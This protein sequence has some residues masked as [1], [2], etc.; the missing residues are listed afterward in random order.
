MSCVRSGVCL[1]LLAWFSL[2]CGVKPPSTEAPRAQ[3]VPTPRPLRAEASDAKLELA[4]QNDGILVKAPWPD[5]EI[6]RGHSALELYGREVRVQVKSDGA[7]LRDHPV[8]DGRTLHYVAVSTNGDYAAATI[9]TPKVKL[10]RVQRPRLVMDKLHYTLSVLDGDTTVKTYAAGLGSDPRKRKICQDNMTTPEG[11]YTIYNLQPEATFF[12]AY[13][14]DYPNMIDRLRY[15]I[16]Q[17]TGLVPSDRGI[18]GEIQIHGR[19]SLGNWTFG[20]ISLDDDD[21]AELFEHPDLGVG[22]ELFICGTEIKLEDRPWL[23]APPPEKVRTVQLAL[24]RSGYYQ[25]TAD[26]LL[27]SQTQEALGRYQVA[28][29]LPLTCQLDSA[30]RAHFQLSRF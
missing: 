25:G 17:E 11:L 21:I 29:K 26:G 15:Q 19:G 10:G 2:G 12:K 13:D 1:F 6:W 3:T 24:Q 5:A 18:G 23:V 14:L 16:G 27:G 9:S 22:M 20:C 8:P 4:R 30:T 7:A 28:K